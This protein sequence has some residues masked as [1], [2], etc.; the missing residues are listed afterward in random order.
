MKMSKQLKAI[1]PYRPAGFTLIELLVVI[2]II[3][4]LAGMLLPVLGKAKAKAH[5]TTCLSNEKQLQLAWTLYEGDA[6]GRLVSN[7]NNGGTLGAGNNTNLT[8]C[9]GW[10]K[11]PTNDGSATNE[12]FFMHGLMGRYAGNAKLFKCPADK[13]VETGRTLTYPR[14][15]SMNNWMN[16]PVSLGNAGAPVYTRSTSLGKPS[17]L[18]VFMHE[19]PNTIEDCVFRQDMYLSGDARNGTFAPGNVPSALHTGATSMGFAD[20]HVESKRWDNLVMV[21]TIPQPA[22]GGSTADKY[23]LKQRAH[24]SFVP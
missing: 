19:T 21:N 8:W 14:S 23:W 4:I 20:G 3:A 10:M 17:D 6:D 9:P 7:S 15:M 18:Y 11:L 24:E 22:D 5:G 16:Y 1:P 2:A 13:Y 12:L